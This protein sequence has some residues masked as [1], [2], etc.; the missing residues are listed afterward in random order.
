MKVLSR[1]EFLALSPYDRGYAVYMMGAREDQPNV[2]DESNP[3]PNGS[4]RADA[5]RRGQQAACLDAQ[6]DG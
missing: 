5:W 6:D 4:R 3:Y 2:P 1:H